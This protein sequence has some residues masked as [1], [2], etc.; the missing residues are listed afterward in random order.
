[1]IAIHDALPGDVLLN[2]VRKTRRWRASA[3]R[4]RIE[5]TPRRSRDPVKRGHFGSSWSRREAGAVLAT[6]HCTNATEADGACGG[7]RRTVTELRWLGLTAVDANRPSRTYRSLG[8]KYA[9][10]A[11]EL[12]FNGAE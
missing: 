2:G 10:H 6:V 1:M 8:P 9:D 5:I 7:Q 4:V 12:A 3:I 11:R